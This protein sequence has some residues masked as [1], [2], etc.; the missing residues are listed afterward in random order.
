MT[1]AEDKGRDLEKIVFLGMITM[2]WGSW[3]W[4]RAGPL[5]GE[6]LA[7]SEDCAGERHGEYG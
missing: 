1:Y 2:L 3:I 4:W 5:V 6:R 7:E